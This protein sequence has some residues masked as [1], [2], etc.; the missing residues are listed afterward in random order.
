MPAGSSRVDQQR[1]EPLHPPKRC[2]VIDVDAT[3]G[4]QLL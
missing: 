3:L 4:Q 2:H 1:S